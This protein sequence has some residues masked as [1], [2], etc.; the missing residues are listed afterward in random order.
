[1]TLEQNWNRIRETVSRAGHCAIASIDEHGA[2]TI[3][4]IGTVFLRDDTTGFY[5]DQY[6]QAL[7]RNLDRD[8]RVCLMAV[9]GRPLYW[10]R[11]LLTARFPSPPGVRLYGTAGPARPATEDEMRQVRARVRIPVRLKGGALLWSDFSQVRDI[12]FTDYRPVRYPH[13]MSHLWQ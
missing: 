3:A 9:D 1:M 8:P 7:G 12:T 4:P 5:F 11:S 13:M 10:F 6:A 2:P